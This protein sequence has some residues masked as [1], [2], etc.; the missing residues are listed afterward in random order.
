M[1]DPLSPSQ[2][3]GEMP[4]DNTLM[5]TPPAIERSGGGSV[6]STLTPPPMYTQTPMH[7]HSPPAYSSSTSPVGLIASEYANRSADIVRGH[8][9][10]RTRE[11]FLNPNAGLQLL[12]RRLWEQTPTGLCMRPLPPLV[13]KPD[14][15]IELKS[16][17]VWDVFLFHD[18]AFAD[19]TIST[20]FKRQLNIRSDIYA[21]ALNHILE[22][23]TDLQ[24]TILSNMEVST[25]LQQSFHQL[26]LK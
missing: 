25:K 10:E 8:Y 24:E 26:T 4:P 20:V 12:E 11:N 15:A 2:S 23:Y 22:V 1:D 6:G 3:A 9:G 18:V 16:L 19:A 21:S 14:Q 13:L 17:I 5:D 7:E